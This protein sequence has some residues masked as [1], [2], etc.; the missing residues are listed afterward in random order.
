MTLGFLFDALVVGHFQWL[1]GRRDEVGLLTLR[2]VGTPPRL[3]EALANFPEDVPKEDYGFFS[4]VP[5][6]PHR[7][8]ETDGV[9]A[10]AHQSCKRN[11]Y[12]IFFSY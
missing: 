6:S 4:V 9:H 8:G 7:G 10:H 5:G 12:Y 1:W 11:N 2:N 3:R